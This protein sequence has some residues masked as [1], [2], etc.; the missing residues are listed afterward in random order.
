MPKFVSDLQVVDILRVGLSGLCFLLSLLA[1]WLISREQ[2]RQGSP[3]ERILRATY[4][5]MVANLVA[6]ILVAISGYFTQ[7]PQA[8]SEGALA[9]D[10][11]LV[12]YT[13]YL[14]DLTQWT[15]KTLG[16]VVITRTDYVR[17]VS[18]TKEDYV[19][20]YFTTGQE[21]TCEP[22]TFSSRPI[23]TRTDD[24]EKK[25]VHYDYRLPI[26]HEPAGHSEMVSSRFT[27]PSGF[28][29]P[30]HEWWQASVAYPTKTVVVTIRFPSD[31][32]GK[33][34]TI[35]R[36]EGIKGKEPITDNLPVQSDNGKV[37]MWVGLNEKGDSRIE[38]DWDW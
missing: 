32:P 4:V 12:D 10:R 15:E 27:F 22:L 13:S 28:R 8:S 36:I 38:F 14:V 23:F 37:A 17:K 20:P 21:I 11:Y 30:Q 1:F 18:D 31:K 6:A 2:S 19:I 24:P 3:R 34:I 33:G 9:A 5:F 26:G 7:R 25:G 16:P 35:S 29:D